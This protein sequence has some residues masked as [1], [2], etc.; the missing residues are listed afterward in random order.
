M[1]EKAQAVVE[2]P[3][4]P[5][6]P[7]QDASNVEDSKPKKLSYSAA[8]IPNPVN[9]HEVFVHAQLVEARGTRN[10]LEKIAALLEDLVTELHDNRMQA[11][12]GSKAE[13]KK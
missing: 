2:A 4:A 9:N 13:P 11:L 7:A 6:T 12:G 3:V 5:N 1:S 10:A 8:S